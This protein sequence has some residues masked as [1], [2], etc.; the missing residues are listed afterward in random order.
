MV[1]RLYFF[2]LIVCLS[3]CV[4]EHG[5]IEDDPAKEFRDQYH[6]LEPEDP[7]YEQEFSED[8]EDGKSNLLIW[9]IFNLIL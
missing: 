2:F 6:E 8:F 7:Y 3:F 9:C 4:I 5:V 1:K